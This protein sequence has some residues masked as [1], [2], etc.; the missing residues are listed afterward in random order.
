M[1]GLFFGHISSLF[2]HLYAQGSANDS[3]SLEKVSMVQCLTLCVIKL[4]TNNAFFCNI[5][6]VKRKSLTILQT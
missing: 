1:L 2:R 3:S 6:T 5:T 4:P